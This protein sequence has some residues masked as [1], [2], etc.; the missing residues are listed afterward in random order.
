MPCFYCNMFIPWDPDYNHAIV[1]TNSTW[2][3]CTAPTCRLKSQNSSLPWP[4]IVILS[5]R[6]WHWRFTSERLAMCTDTTC[7][8]ES[9]VRKGGAGRRMFALGSVIVNIKTVL[10]VLELW[11]MSIKQLPSSTVKLV[12]STQTVTSVSSAV[13]ELMENALDAEAVN[14]D[15][16]LVSMAFYM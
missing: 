16:K 2:W 4:G 12:T 8:A 15:V 7:C 3:I 1:R 11:K 9:Q 5:N 6:C 14:I 13:K 10:S